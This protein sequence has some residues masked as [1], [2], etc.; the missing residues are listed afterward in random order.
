MAQLLL[1]LLSI[2]LLPAEGVMDGLGCQALQLSDADGGLVQAA[3]EAA[4]DL[5]AREAI[6]TQ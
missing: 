6:V 4:H 3:G 5:H 2:L 1:S